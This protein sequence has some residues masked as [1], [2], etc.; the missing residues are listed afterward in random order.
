[1]AAGAW[2]VAAKGGAAAERQA[3]ARAKAAAGAV[4]E[5]VSEVAAGAVVAVLAWAA[6]LEARWVAAC[7]QRAPACRFEGAWAAVGQGA[8]WCQQ[9]AHALHNCDRMHE[10]FSVPQSSPTSVAPP[11]L[12]AAAAACACRTAASNAA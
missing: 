5:G 1:M 10:Q 2:A 4:G 6:G 7:W 11:R 8:R 3:A 9:P 12:A